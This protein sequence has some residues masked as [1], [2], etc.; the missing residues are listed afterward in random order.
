MMIR[1]SAFVDRIGDE[2]FLQAAES[3]LSKMPVGRTASIIHR[4]SNG[5]QTDNMRAIYST[6]TDTAFSIFVSLSSAR[7]TPDLLV[8]GSKTTK[9]KVHLLVRFRP[10]TTKGLMP[11]KTCELQPAN[12]EG[13]YGPELPS[14]ARSSTAET[15]RWFRFDTPLRALEVNNLVPF[16]FNGETA[17]APFLGFYGYELGKGEA[18]RIH[19]VNEIVI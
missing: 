16:E 3:L 18:D 10:L 7:G 8:A 9:I 17:K 2:C 11:A 5:R 13:L 14:S 4:A 15:S 1:Q 12:N 19:S 6:V